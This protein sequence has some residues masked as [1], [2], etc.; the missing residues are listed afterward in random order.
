MN[1]TRLSLAILAATN[2]ETVRALAKRCGLSPSTVSKLISKP[3]RVEPDTLRALCTRAKGDEG[4]KFLLAH[5][6]DEIER[7][8]R[9]EEELVISRRAPDSDDD[10]QLLAD[11]LAQEKARDGDELRAVVQDL[12]KMVRSYRARIRREREDRDGFMAAEHKG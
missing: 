3:R 12:A 6:H 5:I 11:E 7:A 9:S 1:P 8:G 10:L 2:S 4:L